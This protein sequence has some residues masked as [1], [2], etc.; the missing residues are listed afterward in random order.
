MDKTQIRLLMNRTQITLFVMTGWFWFEHVFVITGVIGAGSMSYLPILIIT[1]LL[2]GY[3]GYFGWRYLSSNLEIEQLKFNFKYQFFGMVLLT[4]LFF[5]MCT[6]FGIDGIINDS[7]DISNNN[8]T[9]WHM[10]L[11]LIGNILT[12]LS[13][14]IILYILVLSLK[15]YKNVFKNDSI[16]NSSN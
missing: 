16:Q 7:K 12:V 8:L 5:L 2:A 10:Y 1:N 11:I 3:W 4:G 6:Y 15:M 13:L 14:P 9:K